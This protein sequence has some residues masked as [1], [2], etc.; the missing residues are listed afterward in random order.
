MQSTKSLKLAILALFIITLVI[1]S[2]CAGTAP[3]INY[4]PII[5][6]LTADTSNHIEVNQSTTITC[7]AFDQDNNQL[8]YTW[9]KSGGTIVG[10]DSAVI[11]TAPATAGAYT[12][13]CTVSDGELTATQDFM[14]Q[15]LHQ[16]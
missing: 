4:A 11:W 10:S 7:Y 14:I 15:Y 16:V 6:S 9:T 2:G 12:I 5:I 13:A 1:F 8:T 3:S